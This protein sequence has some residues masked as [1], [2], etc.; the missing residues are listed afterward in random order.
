MVLEIGLT[1]YILFLYLMADSKINLVIIIINIVQKVDKVDDTNL[2]CGSPMDIESK[3]P[4]QQV[5]C[6]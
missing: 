6:L 5:S 2:P 3:K 4:H 1:F